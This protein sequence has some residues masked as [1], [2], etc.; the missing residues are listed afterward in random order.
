MKKQKRLAAVFIA[1][2]MTVCILPRS[3]WADDNDEKLPPVA[4]SYDDGYGA[5]EDGSNEEISSEGD[6]AAYSLLPLDEVRASVDLDRMQKAITQDGRFDTSFTARE[7]FDT[8]IQEGKITDIGFYNKKILFSSYPYSDNYVEITPDSIIA[9]EYINQQ[10]STGSEGVWYSNVSFIVGDG[11]QFNIDNKR[12]EITLNFKFYEDKDGGMAKVSHLEGLPEGSADNLENS[13]YLKDALRSALKADG[14]LDANDG[15]SGDIFYALED[16]SGLQRYT[17]S[18]VKGNWNS[19][20]N[21]YAINNCSG[22]NCY[23][24]CIIPPDANNP[25]TVRYRIYVFENNVSVTLDDNNENYIDR[26]VYNSDQQGAFAYSHAYFFRSADPKFKVGMYYIYY[27]NGTAR[28][29]YTSSQI[30]FACY[31]TY[32]SKSEAEAAGKTNIKDQLFSGSEYSP[33]MT[34]D[35]YQCSN[36]TYYLDANMT[37]PVTLKSLD[38]TVVDKYGSVYNTSIPFGIGSGTEEDVPSGN[39]YFYLYG[40]QISPDGYHYPSYNV[41]NDDS[42]SNIDYYNGYKTAFILNSD[43]TPLPNGTVIYPNFYSAEGSVVHGGDNGEV[44]KAGETPLTF[45]SGKAV[46]YTVGSE[47]NEH[48]GNYW[49]TYVTRQTGDAKLF[50]N[51]VNNKDHWNEQMNMPQREIFFTSN[52]NNYHDIFIANIGDEELTGINVSLSSDATGVKLDGYWTVTDGS[53]RSLAPFTDTNE[54]DNIAKIRLVPE[55]PDLADTISGILTISTANGGEQK[56]NLTGIAGVPRIV[57]RDLYEGVKYVPYSCVIMTNCMHGNNGMKFKLSD[58]SVLP[59]GIELLDN[60]LLYGVPKESG[61]FPISISAV[62][63]PGLS[64]IFNRDTAYDVGSVNYTL[65]IADNTDENVDAVNTGEFGHELTERVSGNITVYYTSSYPI[66]EY[67]S[68]YG[69]LPDDFVIQDIEYDSSMFRSEG[70]YEDFTAFY[71]DGERLSEEAGD[72]SSHSGSTVITVN[73]QTFRSAAESEEDK[74]TLAAEFKQEG[75]SEVKKSAQ[76]FEIKYVYRSGNQSGNNGG[77]NGGNHNTSGSSTW[78]NSNTVKPN[79]TTT[80]STVSVNMTAVSSNG[81][82][83][84]RLAVEL[85]PSTR[86]ISTDNS[87]NAHFNNIKFGRHTLYVTDPDTGEKVSVSFTIQRGQKSSVN[88]NVF[89]AVPGETV[90][91]AVKYSGKKLTIISPVDISADAGVKDSGNNVANSFNFYLFIAAVLIFVTSF[92]LFLAVKILKKNK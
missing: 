63:D 72:Y 41:Y 7:V 54:P 5:P 1:V 68:M 53:R 14:R 85:R 30:D 43:K 55:N 34:A 86:R 65:I 21:T 75:S 12:Y 80:V 48:R 52:Y 19:I 89:T 26:I 39:T 90:N 2:L 9:P 76:N 17:Y 36:V 64:S 6:I 60:G 81:S 47:D 4:A 23:L 24:Y 62:Y 77:N 10:N 11:D 92:A 79:V 91:I 22:I 31:G 84:P 20:V 83:L 57:T 61:E 16:T 44:Q 46:Q 70:E 15:F 37:H 49:V 59:E 33:T 29:D 67:Y 35:L 88:G 78:G 69:K 50:V 58:D 82:V 40:A 71:L 74:H 38:L 8:L 3:V 27:D 73:D 51:G 13:F 56:I 45:E 32:S 28:K 42:Y 18:Y 25:R 66:E 87:G